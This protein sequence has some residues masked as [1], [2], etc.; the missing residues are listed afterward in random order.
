MSVKTPANVKFIKNIS[1][2]KME[3]LNMILIRTKKKPL[4]IL[5]STVTKAFSSR[6]I[7]NVFHF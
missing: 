2:S 1:S 3:K 4:K 6:Q 7:K 5:H